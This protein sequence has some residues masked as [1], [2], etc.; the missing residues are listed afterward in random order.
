MSAE[1]DFDLDAGVDS[2]AEGLGFG[3]DSTQD[4]DYDDSEQL[5]NEEQEEGEF[6]QEEQPLEPQAKQP[7]ASWSKEQ[8]ETWSK[9]P[10][11]AQ[12]YV[13]LREKQM[14]DGIEQ[15]KQGH[16]Y[17]ESLSQAFEPFRGVIEGL[18][19]P[20]EQIVYNL[21]S[22]HAALTQGSLEQRQQALLQIGIATGIVP[23]DGKQAPPVNPIEQDLKQRLER[24]EQMEQKRALDQITQTVEQFASDPKN[25]YFDELADDI[26][27]FLKI[28]DDLQTAYDKA[29]WANPVTRAKE[30]AKTTTV[31]N[32]Q[33]KKLEDAKKASSVNIRGARTSNATRPRAPVGSWED[34]MREEL[35][36]INKS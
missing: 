26:A 16:Q 4:Q 3:E 11:E 28:G 25:E 12:D 6:E 23:Q 7:P 33:S 34:T 17:A 18:G 32:E 1:A 30:M 27:K 35:N 5:D 29:V 14:L 21:L 19:L 10:K 8:H 31:T 2:V 22:H 36:R 24:I 20:D 13:E 15:Y 9:M